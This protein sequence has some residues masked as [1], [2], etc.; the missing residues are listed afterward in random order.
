PSLVGPAIAGAIPAWSSPQIPFA[1]AHRKSASARLRGRFSSSP[2]ESRYFSWPFPPEPTLL[3]RVLTRFH[4]FQQVVQ[5]PKAALPEFPES[6]QPRAGFR[7]SRRLNTPRPALRILP[8][9]NQ[10]CPLE[11]FQVLGNRRLAHAKRLR[12][13]VHRRLPRGK[14]QQNRAAGRIGQRRK[15]R[16]HLIRSQHYITY[17]L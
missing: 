6:L 1:A 15:R 2:A 8:Y 17:R 4:L 3:C 16:I 14:S 12:Q 13:F 5:P 10:P 11:N 9:G 7:Q